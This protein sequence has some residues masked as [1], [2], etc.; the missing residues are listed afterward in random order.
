MKLKEIISALPDVQ[1]VLNSESEITEPV[2]LDVRNTRKDV[3]FWCNDK[4]AEKISQL[5][6]GTVICSKEAAGDLQNKNINYLIVVRPRLCFLKVMELFANNN[7]SDIGIGISPL[8]QIHPSVKTGTGC[9]IGNYVTIE[10]DCRI[11]VNTKIG[12]NTIVR[13]GTVI[14]N[15]VTIGCNNTIGGVGF[16]YEKD[17]DEKYTLIPHLGNVVIKDNVEIGNNTCID[18]AVL[19]S[20][21]ISENV[22]IDNLVHIAH[23]VHIGKNSLI[24]ANAMIGGSTKIGENCWVAPSASVINKGEIGN[25]AVVGMGAVVVKPVE[26]RQTVAGNPAQSTDILKKINAFLKKELGL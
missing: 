25:S 23:G 17:D 5:K 21:M 10:E 22:K 9:A 19:G 11:G 6:A 15:Y 8:A 12:H 26:E 24:I 1:V 16:G 14:G 7:N 2:E 18:R 3:I 4:Y 20:T 13:R